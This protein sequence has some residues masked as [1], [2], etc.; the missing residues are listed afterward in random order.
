M[1]PLGKINR[2][3][4]SFAVQELAKIR[5]AGKDQIVNLKGRDGY[6]RDLE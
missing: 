3:G 2:K 5:T 4:A 1:K 6:A